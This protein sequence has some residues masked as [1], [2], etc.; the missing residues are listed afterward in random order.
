MQFFHLFLAVA[1]LSLVGTAVHAEVVKCKTAD[2]KVVY[3]DQPCISGQSTSTVPGVPNKTASGTA[4]PAGA[5]KPISVPATAVGEARNRAMHARIEAGMSPECRS[6]GVKLGVSL[7]SN[8]DAE[9]ENTKRLF[10]QFDQ[11]CM[12][13]WEK[14][15]KTERDSGSKQ[16]LDATTCRGLRQTRDDARAQLSKMTDQEKAD[17]AKLQNEVSVACP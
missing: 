8:S 12:A 6:I 17:F 14:V 11:R 15:W 9:L 10:T 2:G 5:G 16:P 4:T 7:T 3:S 13:Q 1:W